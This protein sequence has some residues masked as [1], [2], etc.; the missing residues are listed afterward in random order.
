ME[1]AVHEGAILSGCYLTPANQ[2][3]QHT[4]EASVKGQLTPAVGDPWVT[5]GALEHTRV[6]P[7]LGSD[8]AGPSFN[9]TVHVSVA[10][11]LPCFRVCAHLRGTGYKSNS[12]N[13]NNDHAAAASSA[14][15]PATW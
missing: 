15:S 12:N 1:V 2:A 5:P 14:P 3:Q 7:A 8:A 11:V 4:H 10:G 13:N 6:S 9:V